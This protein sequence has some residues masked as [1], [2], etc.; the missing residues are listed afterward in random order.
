MEDSYFGLDVGK[1]LV[2]TLK[3]LKQ[4]GLLQEEEVLDVLWEAKDPL[5]QWT[6]KE[7]KDLLKL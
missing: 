2:G 1:V 3:L 7:I 5:F 4:K 6:K